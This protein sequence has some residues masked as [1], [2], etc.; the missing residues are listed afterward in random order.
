MIYCFFA[1]PTT[2]AFMVIRKIGQDKENL[3][4]QKVNQVVK[5]SAHSR[6]S[7]ARELAKTKK[8]IRMRK[9][10]LYYKN[11]LSHPYYLLYN[12]KKKLVHSSSFS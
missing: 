4:L 1:E 5:I 12:F 2:L 11:Y 9:A 8:K 7:E 6:L 3:N 10:A